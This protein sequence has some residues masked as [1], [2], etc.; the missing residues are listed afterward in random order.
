MGEQKNIL[1]SRCSYFTYERLSL[2][3]P[4]DKIDSA[5]E[6]LVFVMPLF[7]KAL[8]NCRDLWYAKYTVGK[9][10][11]QSH[12]LILLYDFIDALKSNQV[13][14]RILVNQIMLWRD[15]S[16]NHRGWNTN[17][18]LIGYARLSFCLIRKIK[19]VTWWGMLPC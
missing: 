14:I 5:F 3:I 11:T 16:R 8:W 19:K 17:T 13:N 2:E 6:E 12:A 4:P 15:T 9:W 18:L 7:N 1:T 10:K